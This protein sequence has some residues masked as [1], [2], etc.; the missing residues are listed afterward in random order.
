MKQLMKPILKPNETDW[1]EEEAKKFEDDVDGVFMSMTHIAYAISAF[2]LFLFLLVFCC[3]GM[4]M[5]EF[6]KKLISRQKETKNA[7]C[8]KT[9]GDSQPS[10]GKLFFKKHY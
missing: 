3:Y 1:Y 6:L 5:V 7:T 9:T 2:V 4:K 10:N 8:K